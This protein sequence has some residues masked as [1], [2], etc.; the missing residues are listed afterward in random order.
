MVTFAILV[1]GVHLVACLI[2]IAAFAAVFAV[3]AG[4]CLDF[5]HL[6]SSLMALSLVGT[7]LIIM[8]RDAHCIAG[9]FNHRTVPETRY[10]S[11]QK[12][13]LIRVP[14]DRRYRWR[15]ETALGWITIF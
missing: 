14:D 5:P 4:G 11:G 12:Q 6:C 8:V 7:A 1:S 13:P 3:V 15:D 10:R 2:I 9:R